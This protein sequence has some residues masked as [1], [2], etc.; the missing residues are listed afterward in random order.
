MAWHTGAGM[1]WWM[2]FG[3]FLWVVFW[4]TVIYFFVTLFRDPQAGASSQKEED[5]I[6]IAKRRY[7]G[8][9]IT[10]DEYERIRHDLAA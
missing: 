8:G 10:S 7:A 1:G 2:V 5:P 3:G 9:Q 6:D 4:G